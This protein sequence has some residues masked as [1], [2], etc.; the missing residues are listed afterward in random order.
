M[1]LEKGALTEA[2]ALIESNKKTLNFIS[3]SKHKEEA[4]LQYQLEGDLALNFEKFERATFNYQKAVNVYEVTGTPPLR[5]RKPLIDVLFL[6]GNIGE[7]YRNLDIWKVLSR[8]I[9]KEKRAGR[10]N[11]ILF[12]SF[13]NTVKLKLK[14]V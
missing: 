3:P 10:V 8:K 7:V 11:L 14:K 12:F 13:I 5:L 4:A 1:L 2:Q 9:N 6:T